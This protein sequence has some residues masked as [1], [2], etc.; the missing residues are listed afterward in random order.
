MRATM[1]SRIEVKEGR[2]VEAI[3]SRWGGGANMF[4][5]GAPC[6]LGMGI[7]AHSVLVATV[8]ET[9]YQRVIDVIGVT[10]CAVQKEE[11]SRS[12]DFCSKCRGM[13]CRCGRRVGRNCSGYPHSGLI[14]GLEFAR[15]LPH[16][17]QKH[18]QELFKSVIDADW[19][20]TFLPG[21][22]MSAQR[23]VRRSE[24]ALSPESYHTA[25]DSDTESTEDPQPGKLS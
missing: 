11:V 4:M 7:Y 22:L 8:G 2:M 19:K 14:L 13:I 15:T 9:V 1:A 23:L 16:W 5:R 6:C 18:S 12:M 3:W 21:R 24:Q 17:W 20:I 25:E 10:I